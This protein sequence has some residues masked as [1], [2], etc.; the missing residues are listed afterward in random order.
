MSIRTRLTLWYGG[1]LALILLLFGGALYTILH[2]SLLSGIDRTLARTA[3]QVQASARRQI[4]ITPPFNWEEV[5]TLPPL[6]VFAAPGV[7]VQVRHPNG[8]VAATSANLLGQ[9]LPELPGSDAE[10]VLKG[11][12][13]LRTVRVGTVRVRLRSE[14][15]VADGRAVGMLQVGA[16]LQQVDEA[17]VRLLRLLLAGGGLGLLLAVLGGSLLSRQ[18]LAPISRVTETARRIA[19]TDDLGER[20]AAPGVQDEVGRLVSTFNEML[21]RLQRLF[22]GQ[23][24]FITDLSHELRTPLAAIR[25]N[26]EVLQRGAGAD[27]EMLQESLRDIERE[28]ARLSRMVA[29][30]LAL[31]RADAGMHLER[32]PVQLDALLLEVYREARHLA[33]GIEVRLGSED[34]VEIEGDPDRLKQLLLNLVD[35]AL[36]FTPPGGTVTLSLY[37]EGPWACLS[38]Q[39]TGP[40]IAPEDLPHLFERFYRGRTAGRR[41]GMG[42]GLSIARWIADEHGGQIT[43]ET[44]AGEG[45]TF[46]VWLPLPRAA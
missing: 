29:D 36:K 13:D 22:Q 30:L 7:F 2:G 11:A 15:I 41:G 39:D 34:Q 6:D 42:L 33:R 31:A 8:T 46:T 25:G 19:H 40:G 35:N 12:V 5:I 44:R 38:V 26:L 4:A 28:V 3:A 18:A 32:R 43:V 23:Q 17:L 9:E 21:D 37:R 27:P 1:I 16:S 45:S 24:R 10:Q 20:I 14:A